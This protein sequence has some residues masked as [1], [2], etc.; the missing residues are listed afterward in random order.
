MEAVIAI[1]GARPFPL[2]QLDRLL[3][4]LVRRAWRKIEQGGRPAMEG[5]PA[6]LLR[7]RAQHILVAAGERYRRAAMD[8]RI[9]ATRYHDLPGRV[10]NPRCANAREASKPANRGDF[11]PADP[12][13]GRVRVAARH[14]RF[15]GRNNQIEH[16][17]RSSPKFRPTSTSRPLT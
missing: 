12:D 4:R 6:D 15:A 11:A 7:R 5:G 17:I 10:D 14:H 13:I 9:D 1:A 2:A 8:V 16:A 3:Q